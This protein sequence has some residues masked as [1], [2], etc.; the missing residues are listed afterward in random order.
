MDVLLDFNEEAMTADV[1]LDGPDLST[2][3][4]LK[5]AIVVSLF[6]DRRAPASFQLPAGDDDPRGFWGDVAPANDV[7]GDETGSHLWLLGREKETEETRT[8]A[9]AY[10]RTALAWIVED[11]VAERVDVEGEWVGRGRL[12]LKITVHRPATTPAA[13]S[14]AWDTAG[15]TA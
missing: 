1:L 5:T 4:G 7:E 3:E 11:G 14:F 9:V 15:E 13:Y 6:T 8:R 2:D 10:C 12:G